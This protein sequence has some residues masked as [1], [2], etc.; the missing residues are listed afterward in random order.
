MALVLSLLSTCCLWISQVPTTQ[1]FLDKIPRLSTDRG[2]DR[3][4]QRFGSL[5]VAR[6]QLSLRSRG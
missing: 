4:I 5:R 1:S 3:S 2:A 6:I